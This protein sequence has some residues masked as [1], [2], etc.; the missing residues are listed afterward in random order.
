MEKGRSLSMYPAVGIILSLLGIILLVLSLFGGGLKTLSEY[1]VYLGLAFFIGGILILTLSSQTKELFE[2]SFLPIKQSDSRNKELFEKS[3]LAILGYFVPPEVMKEVIDYVVKTDVF[4]KNY[5]CNIQISEVEEQ[6]GKCLRFDLFTNFEVHN[7]NVREVEYLYSER[8]VDIDMGH[9]VPVPIF[10]ELRISDKDNLNVQYKASE[11]DFKSKDI[12][13]TDVRR[14]EKILRVNCKI[15]PRDFIRVLA[16]K[17]LF[18][19]ADKD[20]YSLAVRKPCEDMTLRATFP[21]DEYEYWFL[22]NRPDSIEEKKDRFI[23]NR[24]PS[25]NSI[26]ARVIGGLLPYQNIQLIYK[27]KSR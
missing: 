18:L 14:G 4:Y 13:H 6:R 12:E 5:E 23:V 27:Q 21:N 16:S 11:V 10:K 19:R 25:S 24:I 15:P 17:S 1:R 22:C 3:F 26:E 7:P 2:K 8:L 20:Y 9:E